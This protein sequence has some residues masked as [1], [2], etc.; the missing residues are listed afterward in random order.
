MHSLLKNFDSYNLIGSCGRRNIISE[1]HFLLRKSYKIN[2]KIVP[3]LALLFA[4]KDGNNA[5]NIPY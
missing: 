3:S 1:S 5:R 2:K 4:L